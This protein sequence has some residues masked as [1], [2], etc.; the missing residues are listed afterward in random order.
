MIISASYKTDIPT[1]YGDWFINRLRAGYCKMV[2]PYN[3]RVHQVDLRRQVVDGFIFWTKNVGPFLDHLDEVADGGFPFVVQHTING[4]PRVLE[5]SVV[6]ASQSIEHVQTMAR[7]YGA[8]VP[9]WRYDTIVF[10]SQTTVDFHRRNFEEIA[11]R[12]SGAIDEVVISFAQIYKKTR[13]N[14][15]AAANGMD[16][17][18][19]DPPEALKFELAGELAEIAHAEGMQLSIC[20]QKRFLSPGV[21]EARCVD[22]KRLSD[23][24]GQPFR[25][26][27]QGN[28]PDCACFHSRDIGEY[29]TC[30]HGCVYC[31]AVQNRAL[32]LRRYRRHD[33]NDEFLFSPSD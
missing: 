5:T 17:E 24:A 3:R 1:F 18:W 7:R 32:A 4:Y 16:F 20:A 26:K 13:R 15:D 23:I 31:Y 25:A 30:P 6:D 33:P 27:V 12:L 29:D 21:N 11:R 22:A 2:N 19:E 28:R 8:R 10:S 14:M 9:V